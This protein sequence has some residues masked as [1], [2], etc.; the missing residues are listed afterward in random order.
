M[1][2]ALAELHGGLQSL[3]AEGDLLS[4]CFH[5]LV[6]KDRFLAFIRETRRLLLSLEEALPTVVE[7]LNKLRW[8]VTVHDV[9][10]D[11]SSENAYRRPGQHGSLTD[12]DYSSFKHAVDLLRVA[13]LKV[14]M[15]IESLVPSTGH[16]PTVPVSPPARDVL[17]QTTAPG[18]TLRKLVEEGAPLKE[19]EAARLLSVQ[20]STLQRRR[21]LGKGPTFRKM[22]RAVRYMPA[23]IRDY[24]ERHRSTEEDRH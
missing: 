6:G 24:L 8:T 4:G 17:P 21:L 14:R 5:Q 3:I 20:V 7:Q 10:E 9:D 19:Q 22:G 15:D 23:D 12:F 13:E 11:T 2:S 18:P 16:V 1:E